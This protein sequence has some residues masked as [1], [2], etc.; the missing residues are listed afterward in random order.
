MEDPLPEETSSMFLELRMK[1]RLADSKHEAN[2]RMIDVVTLLIANLE[3][4]DEFLDSA[5]TY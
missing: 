1:V 3:K 2:P 5:G 4:A